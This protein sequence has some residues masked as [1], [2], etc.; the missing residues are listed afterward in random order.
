MPNHLRYLEGK[1]FCVIFVKAENENKPD[2]KVK[3]KCFYGRANIDLMGACHIEGDQ[4]RFSLPHSVYPKIQESDGSELLKGAE[5]FVIIRV[6][7]M[8]L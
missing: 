6:S 7:G 3:L 8:E 4:G 2:E 1:S 5:H